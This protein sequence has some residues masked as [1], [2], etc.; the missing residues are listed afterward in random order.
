[1]KLFLADCQPAQ[2]V[3]LDL[4]HGFHRVVFAVVIDWLGNRA[5]LT[6][7]GSGRNVSASGQG[8]QHQDC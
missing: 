3:R 6:D 5:K 2:I 8:G 4:L 1:M 7:Y